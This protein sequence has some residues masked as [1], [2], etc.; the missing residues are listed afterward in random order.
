MYRLIGQINIGGHFQGIGHSMRAIKTLILELTNN[1]QIVAELNST[2]QGS[3]EM[4]YLNKFVT[5]V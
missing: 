5:G 3:N 4:K 2:V 1:E